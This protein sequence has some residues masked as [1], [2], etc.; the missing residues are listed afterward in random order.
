MLSL[1]YDI[2]VQD[3]PAHNDC[4]A[5]LGAYAC[6][7]PGGF[8]A[9]LAEGA[10]N[11]AGGAEGQEILISA[12]FVHHP[13]RMGAFGVKQSIHGSHLRVNITGATGSRVILQRVQVGCFLG[14]P[15]RFVKENPPIPQLVKDR[16]GTGIDPAD[17]GDVPFLRVI[18]KANAIKGKRVDLK[19]AGESINSLQDSVD[20]V[21]DSP[22]DGEILG[23][24]RQPSKG[25]GRATSLPRKMKR[26]SGGGHRTSTR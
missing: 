10:G 17:F 18:E 11:N 12:D 19:V 9:V 7:F 15:I 25:G 4:Q 13:G 5:F 3:F 2:D 20:P 23:E 22:A 21:V 24:Q 14:T 16:T 8:C 26:R 1:V 6:V